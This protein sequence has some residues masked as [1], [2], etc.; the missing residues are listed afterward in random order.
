MRI[1]NKIVEIST[2]ANK[3]IQKRGAFER[4]GSAAA[5]MDQSY[6]EEMLG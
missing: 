2:V 6:N 1:L 3:K 4:S 5:E